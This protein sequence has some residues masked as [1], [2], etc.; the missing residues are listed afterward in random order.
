MQAIIA[1]KHPHNTCWVTVY[2][3]AADLPTLGLLRDRLA[4]VGWVPDEFP[5]APPFDDNHE[6]TFCSP[7]CGLFNG[8]TDAEAIDKLAAVKRVL[9]SFRIKAVR[10][11]LT[12]ADCL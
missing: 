2:Y 7:G 1:S 9:R 11:R 4:G 12:L 3:R 8:W 5:P 10:H 6:L